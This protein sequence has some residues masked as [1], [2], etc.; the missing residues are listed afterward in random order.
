M[1]VADPRSFGGRYIAADL[2][3]ETFAAYAESRESRNRYNAPVHNS[4]AVLSA[5]QFRRVLRQADDP[6]RDTVVLLTGIPGAGKT[7]SV[8]AGGGLSNHAPKLLGRQHRRRVVHR[9]VVAVARLPGFRVSR[10]G[11]LEQIGCDVPATERAGISHVHR[12]VYCDI[13][14][15]S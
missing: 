4:A 9:R 1:Y 12:E 15:P 5:E 8:L 6:A 10:E 3:K 11:L 2:F 14:T 13:C 7:S